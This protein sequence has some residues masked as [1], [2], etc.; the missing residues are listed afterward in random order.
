LGPDCRMAN[1]ES[2]LRE[3]KGKR[4]IIGRIMEETRE[5][6][7]AVKEAARLVVRVSTADVSVLLLLECCYI[8]PTATSSTLSRR[9]KL[10]KLSQAP[11]VR[12]LIPCSASRRVCCVSSSRRGMMVLEGV[13]VMRVDADACG[14]W[15]IKAR[16]ASQVTTSSRRVRLE[17]ITRTRTRI[18]CTSPSSKEDGLSLANT[19]F[20]V[21]FA[22]RTAPS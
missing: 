2:R 16:V 6:A 21:C 3:R 10:L 22:A 7:Q 11:A 18:A 15:F 19:I 5:F 12:L 1:L 17:P 9:A 4:E 8:N 20:I 14:A 13:E